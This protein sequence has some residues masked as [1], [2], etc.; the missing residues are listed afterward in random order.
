VRVLATL[1]PEHCTLVPRPGGSSCGCCGCGAAREA[2]R[3][4]AGE[5]E[6]A[7]MTTSTVEEKDEKQRADGKMT[8]SS[9]AS[10]RGEPAGCAD[11]TEHGLD[12]G[13][14]PCTA[15]AVTGR[16]GRQADYL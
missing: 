10:E 4:G 8:R 1:P 13:A 9:R 3:S 11:P 12:P 15:P 2:E 14:E 16:R 7:V 5:H 6:E